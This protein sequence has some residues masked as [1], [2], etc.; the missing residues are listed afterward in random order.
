MRTT[1]KT[2][3]Q[4]LSEQTNGGSGGSGGSGGGTGG[5]GGGNG[6]G[7]GNGGMGGN[8]GSGN[9]NSDGGGGMMPPNGTSG[10]AISSPIIS[11]GIGYGPYGYRQRKGCKYGR[12][13]DG[14]CR[15]KPK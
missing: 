14:K 4:A 1:R 13:E 15:K 9:D 6:A 11:R 8:G 5:G 12:R 10:K 3:Y 2:L 7:G